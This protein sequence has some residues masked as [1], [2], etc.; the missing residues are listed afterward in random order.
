MAD[1]RQ[2]AVWG[3]AATGGAGAC[4]IFG[5]AYLIPHGPLEQ[6]VHPLFILGVT[7]VMGLA[8]AW[9]LVFSRKGFRRADEYA[10]QASKFSWYWGGTGGLLLSAPVYA[11]IALGGLH[12][13]WP[14][15]FHL[16]RDLLR[17][18][19]IG[20]GLPVVM[21]MAGFYAARGWWSLRRR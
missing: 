8:M 2:R 10:Q 4:A 3:Y 17:A 1:R 18:F 13:L 20:Y 16:G 21:Q 11:F 7:V 15:S 9:V 14:G 19:M 6:G 12:W 5:L